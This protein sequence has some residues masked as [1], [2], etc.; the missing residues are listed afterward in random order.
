MDFKELEDLIR[1][2][3][4]SGLAELEIEEDGRRIRLQ[5]SL[6]VAPV[7]AAMA[8]VDSLAL[9]AAAAGIPAESEP[10]EVEEAEGLPTITA[11]MVGTFYG[12][13]APGEEPFVSVGDTVE[14][15]QTVC[16]VEAMKLMN[17]IGATIAGVIEE[18]LVE[19]GQPVEF[20]QP[21]FSI[22]TVEV[23]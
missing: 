22:R 21:L 10:E 19:N 1:I 6:P 4:Q 13:P 12:A 16:I 15:G 5:K 14:E 2:L 7:V 18:F 23:E 17:E 11:P 3:E 20:G 9:Q 8:P